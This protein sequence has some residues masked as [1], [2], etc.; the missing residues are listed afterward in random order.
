MPA[1]AITTDDSEWPVV[2]HTT[3]GIPSQP[4][5]DAFIKRADMLLAL[6]QRHVVIFDNRLAGRVPA[7]MRQ[8]SFDWV[9]AN[10]ADLERWCA[11]TALVLSS[12]GLRFLMTTMM[13]VTSHSL[14]QE[15]FKDRESA[16]KWARERLVTAQAR[17]RP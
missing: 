16:M 7:Y 8:R 17:P 14:V 15:V 11:G 1:D 13:L 12:P 4:E 6:H 10:K 5:V 9:K 3:V 2:V